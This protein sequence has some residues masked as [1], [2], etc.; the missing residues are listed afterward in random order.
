MR[1]LNYKEADMQ[2]ARK[3]KLAPVTAPIEELPAPAKEEKVSLSLVVP[4]ELHHRVRLEAMMRMQTVGEIIEEWVDQNVS[5]E[6]ITLTPEDLNAVNDD[7]VNPDIET[8][9]LSAAISRR[10]HNLIRLETLRRKTTIRSLVK[11]WISENAREF[12]PVPRTMDKIG[13]LTA[14]S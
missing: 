14:A 9:G 6:A 4:V 13:P 7:P 10:H 2:A 3:L 5:P 1:S 11:A 12:E 8:K